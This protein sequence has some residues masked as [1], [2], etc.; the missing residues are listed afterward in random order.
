MF[1]NQVGMTKKWALGTCIL[2]PPIVHV[3]VTMCIRSC[4]L[5]FCLLCFV[6]KNIH[7]FSLRLDDHRLNLLLSDI[8]REL[9]KGT[10][11]FEGENVYCEKL[12]HMY[13]VR[14]VQ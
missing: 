12:E 14:R 5:A 6:K 7:E 11:V 2:T 4:Y 10:Y 1:N 13:T 8:R 3:Y 9:L